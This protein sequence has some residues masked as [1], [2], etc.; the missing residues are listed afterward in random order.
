V[1]VSSRESLQP[2][3]SRVV[4]HGAETRA[5]GSRDPGSVNVPESRTPWIAVADTGA[6]IGNG[7]KSAGTAVAGFFTRAGRTVASSF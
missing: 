7:A 4:W 3:E 1:I 2:L 6:A 5:I